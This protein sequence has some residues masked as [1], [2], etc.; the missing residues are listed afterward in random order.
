MALKRRDRIVVFRLSQDEYEGLKAV[1]AARRAP[2]IS[3][4]A[5]SELL[6]AL[7]RDRR[8]GLSQQLSSLQSSIRRMT[9]ILEKIASRPKES[10]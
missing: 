6:L 9:Q 7:D 8:P 5:R 1:C 3:S 10:A 4:F 2:S